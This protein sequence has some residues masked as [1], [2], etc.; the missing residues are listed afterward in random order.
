MI[1]LHSVAGSVLVF[2]IEHVKALRQ[3][4]IVGVLLGTLPKAPQQNVFLG[5][6]LQLSAYETRWLLLKHLVV[7]VDSLLFNQAVALA[8]TTSQTSPPEDSP[9]LV[10]P[11]SYLDCNVNYAA[12]EI[13]LDLFLEALRQPPNFERK[14]KAFSRLRDAEYVLMPGLR[15]G[16]TFVA[17]PGDPLQYHS[18]LIVKVPDR[19]NSINLQ[20]LITSGRLATAVKK[21]WVIV[22]HDED[23]ED[24]LTFSVEWSGFG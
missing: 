15:F 18:H 19:G 24:D 1:V 5:L 23:E 13:S 11:D 14:Y 10:T 21:V 12:Y 4:G 20:D 3:L 2:D 9:F 22:D 16:G 17:Y 6:P 8:S 7:L